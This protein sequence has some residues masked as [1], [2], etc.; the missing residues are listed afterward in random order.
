MYAYFLVFTGLMFCLLSG[1]LAILLPAG[2]ISF[3]T[4]ASMMILSLALGRIGHGTW[5][6]NRSNIL[7]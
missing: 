6:I 2:P 3:V 5:Q 4:V 7:R 1:V